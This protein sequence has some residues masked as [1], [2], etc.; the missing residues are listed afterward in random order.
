MPRRT[1][2]PPWHSPTPLSPPPITAT[3]PPTAESRNPN[4]LNAISAT[5]LRL[6]NSRIRSRAAHTAAP[7]R[8]PAPVLLTQ[9]PAAA[10][11]NR[12]PRNDA[13]VPAPAPLRRSTRQSS[14]VP[15]NELTPSVS[16]SGRSL[17]THNDTL[18]RIPLADLP[19]ALQKQLRAQNAASQPEEQQP[20]KPALPIDASQNSPQLII[21]LDLWHPPPPI[22]TPPRHRRPSTQLNNPLQALFRSETNEGNSSA[23]STPATL[24]P[25]HN[26]SIPANYPAEGGSRLT[27]AKRTSPEQLAAALDNDYHPTSPPQAPNAS[28]KSNARHRRQPQLKFP[29]QYAKEKAVQTAPPPYLL[30]GLEAAYYMDGASVNTDNS[31]RGACAYLKHTPQRSNIYAAK[32][33]NA[34]NNVAEFTALEEALKDAIQFN[35]SVVLFVT[36]SQLVFDFLIGANSVS[37]SHLREIIARL[38][39]LVKKIPTIYASKVYSH[40]RDAYLGNQIADALCTWTLNSQKS[41]PLRIILST[42]PLATR[43]LAFNRNDPLF[44]EPSDTGRDRCALC[45]KACDHNHLQCPTRALRNASADHQACLACLATDHLA[46]TCPLYL[47]P[48]SRPAVAKST[49][50]PPVEPNP[51]LVDIMDID[52]D[53]IQFPPRQSKE[54]FLDYFETVFSTLLFTTDMTR[55]HSAEKAIVEWAKHYHFVQNSIYRNRDRPSTHTSDPGDNMHPNPRDEMMASAKRA[56]KAAALGVDAKIGDVAKALRSTP[57]LELTDAVQDILK[58]LYPP[59]KSDPVFFEPCPLKS[60]DLSRHAVARAIMSRSRTSHPGTLGLNYA[61]LQ[62]YCKWTY[63]L[64]T[65][66]NPDPRWTIFC[67]LISKI[68]TGNAPLMSPMLHQVFG[69]FFNK[70]FEKPGAPISIRNIGV[71]ETLLRI[72]ATLVFEHVVQDAID[73]NFL[74]SFDLGVGRKAGAEIFAKIAEMAAVNGAIIAVMDVKKAFNNIR[75]KDIKEATAE[76]ANPLLSA[77]LAFL[78]ERNPTVTFKDRSSGKSLICILLEGILQGN[79]LST[80]IFA[81]TIAYILR[82]LRA[83]FQHHSIA[84]AFVDDMNLISNAS[85][86]HQYPTMLKEFFETFNAHGLEFDFSNLAKTSVYTVAPLPST[87]RNQLAKLGVKTQNDGIAPCKCPIGKDQFVA[88]FVENLTAKLTNRF[89]ALDSLWPAL[90]KHDAQKQRPTRRTHEHYLTLIRL[91]FLSMPMYTLRSL[92]PSLCEPYACAATRMAKSLID[93]V[94]PPLCVLPGRPT[95]PLPDQYPDMNAVHE[96]IVQLP[97]SRGGASLRFA[98]SIQPIA[99]VSSCIDCSETIKIAASALAMKFS[100]DAFGEF[101]TTRNAIIANTPTITAG[102]FNEIYGELSSTQTTAQ[103]TLT[104]FLNDHE[105]TRISDL[106]RTVPMYHHAFMARTDPKQDHA[107]WPFNPRTRAAFSI[108]ALEDPL[109]SR[110]LQLA[111]LRPAFDAPYL[112]EG[113]NKQMIDP[114]GLHLLKC[115]ATHY[116]LIHDTIK[117]SL[118]ARL[119]SLLTQQAAVLA[120]HV[121]P[122][123][124]RFAKLRFP[125]WTEGPALRADLIVVLS[126]NT[127]QAVLVTDIVS[128]LPTAASRRAS[129]Y[130]DLEHEEANKRTKYWK[131]FIAPQKFF[132]IAVGRTNSLSRDTLRFCEAVGN[133][134]PKASKVSDKLRATLSRAIT[135]GVASTYN[136]S[137]RRLQLA[138]FNSVAFSMVPPVP[139]RSLRRAASARNAKV[140]NSRSQLSSQPLDNTLAACLSR[141]DYCSPSD[142]G[143]DSRHASQRTRDADNT[144]EEGDF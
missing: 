29:M 101:A 85:Q 15:W 72:P 108:G 71:E 66:D 113:C 126:E 130:T 141:D 73:R 34:T 11:P 48:K 69:F 1:A 63:K 33:D 54:Q 40:R 104:R 46:E 42:Q 128:T 2:D 9:F 136:E 93:K 27:N 132:A 49:K 38:K 131:Y 127:Q 120:V 74:T 98:T 53:T 92:K 44:T 16:A 110:A 47:D 26:P 50:A 81:L 90:L 32:L 22:T 7:T 25:A 79:P 57:S 24:N 68:M 82:P 65:R 55:Q 86:K 111:T 109:F 62:Q 125:Q 91:S 64:E 52:F 129:F 51:N 144:V 137:I 100:M 133:Y 121:E 76:F 10:A 103:Q 97:L 77:F 114:V 123:V 138:A 78:F 13:P 88:D 18:L 12:T 134:F 107:S 61:I 19:P 6:N 28:H 8:V 105:I 99:Y 3:P 94:F 59:A 23:S 4:Q 87:V 58:S 21:P 80:F 39:L 14:T 5:Q 112:C 35:H 60:F 70:N 43:L 140:H 95:S 20:P 45:F 75:R 84:T 102:T 89:L 30:Y 118:A 142:G 143:P 37:L 36:D 67:E 122:L 135:A 119:R 106:L 31:K 116:S 124:N 17:T 41:A 56:E 117:H 83:K 115:Q 96:G 139:N